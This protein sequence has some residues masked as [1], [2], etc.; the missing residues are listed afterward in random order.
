MN[1][2]IQLPPDGS[3]KMVDADSLEV[4]SNT[5]YRE[6]DRIAGTN[7]DELSDVRGNGANA[8]ANDYGVVVRQAPPNGSNAHGFSTTLAKNTPQTIIT[9]PNI[10]TGATGY[11]LKAILASTG[12]AIWTIAAAG[13]ALAYV[14]TSGNTFV[15]E[16]PRGTDSCASGSAFTVVCESIDPDFSTIGGYATLYWESYVAPS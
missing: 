15:Y 4:D 3:G 16:P 6:R 13:S 7:A 8:G 12:M 14:L 11:A 1:D 9:T 5:V 2:F 10:A